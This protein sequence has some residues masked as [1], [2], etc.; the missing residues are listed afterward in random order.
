MERS[1]KN[2][3]PMPEETGW[4]GASAEKSCATC[5]WNWMETAPGLMQQVPSCH[6]NPR[7]CLIVNGQQLVGAIPPIAN[8]EQSLCE[9]WKR[10]K[11][12]G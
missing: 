11:F 3:Q 2:D 7:Q 8:P 10:R 12:D 9:G 6:R 4:C 1:L 5:F